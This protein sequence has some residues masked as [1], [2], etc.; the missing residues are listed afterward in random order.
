MR[1]DFHCLFRYFP[2]RFNVATELVPFGVYESPENLRFELAKCT[3]SK[4]NSNDTV[5][6]IIE[7]LAK[8]YE[9][10]VCIRV[11]EIHQHLENNVG[12]DFPNIVY[13][14]KTGKHY[15]VLKQITD[16]DDAIMKR[17]KKLMVIVRKGRYFFYFYKRM[18]R[19]AKMLRND[20]NLRNQIDNYTGELLMQVV[21]ELKCFFIFR[22]KK[23]LITETDSPGDNKLKTCCRLKKPYLL[24]QYQDNVS[25]F[26]DMPFNFDVATA[27]LLYNIM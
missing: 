1:G 27:T 7:A 16:V 11:D 17:K 26:L 5:D 2:N 14:I 23:S 6:L 4:I 21:T 18:H 10:G 8:A 15:H 20:K 9:A 24:K 25:M 22:G 13:L 3:F 12:M 19:K